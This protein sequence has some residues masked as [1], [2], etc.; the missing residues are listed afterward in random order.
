LRNASVALPVSCG[1]T[2]DPK[3]VEIENPSP[4]SESARHAAS[5]SAC[6][7]AAPAMTQNSSPPGR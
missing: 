7:V 6:R 2:T 3:A 1:M 5:S 4:C